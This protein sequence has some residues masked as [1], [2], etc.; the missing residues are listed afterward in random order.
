VTKETAC[1]TDILTEIGLGLP[2]KRNSTPEKEG[3][4][5]AEEATV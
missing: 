3:S 5:I 4:S 2:R 1:N